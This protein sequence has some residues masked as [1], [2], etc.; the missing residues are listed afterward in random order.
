MLFSVLAINSAMAAAGT[1]A[2]PATTGFWSH[3]EGMN[4][5]TVVF[6]SLCIFA[7]AYRFYGVFIANKVLRL[8]ANRTTPAVKYADGHDYVKTN[9]GTPSISKCTLRIPLLRAPSTPCLA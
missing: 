7:I 4:A 8:D 2:A 1:P 9:K 3:F 5:L 6:A